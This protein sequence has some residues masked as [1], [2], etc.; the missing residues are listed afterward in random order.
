MAGSL[1]KLQLE[2][3]FLLSMCVPDSCAIYIRA[4]LNEENRQ[5][6]V[7]T[8]CQISLVFNSIQCKNEYTFCWIKCSDS[9]IISADRQTH[10]CTR[11]DNFNMCLAYTHVSIVLSSSVICSPIRTQQRLKATPNWNGKILQYSAYNNES[12][13]EPL[14][15]RERE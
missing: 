13:V 3:T 6:S 8:K 5:K 15:I 4:L 14:V 10:I 11:N 9:I 1:L 12:H 7:S 2:L